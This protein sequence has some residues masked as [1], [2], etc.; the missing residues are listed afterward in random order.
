M[1]NVAVIDTNIEVGRNTLEKYISTGQINIC[2]ID[3]INYKSYRHGSNVVEIILK[4]CPTAHINVFP[5]LNES[6]RGSIKN[7]CKAIETCI[8]LNISLINLSLGISDVV[9]ES[10]EKNR[11]EELCKQAQSKGIIIVAAKSNNGDSC[12]AN[13]N[14]VVGV[15]SCNEIDYAIKVD[16]DKRDVI[17]QNDYVFLNRDRNLLIKG[18]SYLTAIISGVLCNRLLCDD[19]LSVDGAIE[20]I[21]DV[22]EKKQNKLWFTSISKLEEKILHRKVAFL[23]ISK[24]EDE[25]SISRFYEKHSNFAR[26]KFTQFEI[27]KKKIK[28]YHYLAIGIPQYD[29]S[30]EYE[31]LVQLINDISC[32][33]EIILT[34]PLISLSQ[35]INKIET[36]K[37]SIYSLYF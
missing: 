24:S 17:F 1:L 8:D 9:K 19:C 15:G 4:E 7:L 21:K 27:L 13:L 5:I 11:L 33:V 20:Y 29:C 26:Y 32:N 16:T 10:S 22:L 37:N 34:V 28:D 31:S 30:Q 36:N 14:T 18:N 12:P 6:K 2:N 25:N 23:E 3:Q 35:R